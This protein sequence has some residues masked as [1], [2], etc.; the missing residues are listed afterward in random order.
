M[1]YS[2]AAPQ[3]AFLIIN[4]RPGADDIPAVQCGKRRRQL[5]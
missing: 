2:G 1:W 3:G 4:V 5:R